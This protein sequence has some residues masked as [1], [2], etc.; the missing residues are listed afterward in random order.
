MADNN[1][2][3]GA[4]GFE[5]LDAKDESLAKWKAMLGLGTN[6]AFGGDT[7]KPMVHLCL[8]GFARRFHLY[9][10]QLSVLSLELTSFSLPPGK[11]ITLDFSNEERMKYNETNP[12]QVKEGVAYE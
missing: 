10:T 2:K 7:S 4:D 1:I 3:E 8:D 12:I 11:S 6:A 5:T 9:L